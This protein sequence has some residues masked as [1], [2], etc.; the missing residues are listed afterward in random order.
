[1]TDD[2][3]SRAT[4]AL[5]NLFIGDAL[6]MPVHWFY[7]VHDIDK[8]FPDGIKTFEAPPEFHPSSIMSLHSTSGGGRKGAGNQA[9]R[10]IVGGVILKGKQSF[11]DRPNVHYHQG[12]R[13]GDN[14]LNAYCAL[15]LM[16]TMGES[17]GH[18]DQD[19]FLQAYIKLMTSDTPA[20]PDTYAE[21][22]HRGFF[23]NLEAGLPAEQCGAV[24]HDTPSVGGLVTIAPLA[25]GERLRGRSLAETQKLCRDHLALTHP[26]SFLA[27]VCDAY[28]ALIDGLL[29]RDSERNAESVQELLLQAARGLPRRDLTKLVNSSKPEREVV[30]RVLSTACYISDSWPAVLYLACKHQQDPLRALQINAEIGG[31][32]VHRGAVLGVLLGLIHGEAAGNLFAQLTE[33]KSINRAIE[34]LVRSDAP[35]A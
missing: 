31:D 34:Q 24:T 33:H 28:V 5:S 29:F 21:S 1:M 27:D 7:N 32:S 8:A 19:N 9:P 30:G 6:A 35:T 15:T 14:T 18:Y 4:A 13:P 2:V 23:A 11:W 22:Y 16:E 20:H 17:G 3:T 10:D 26:D 12:M 25:I